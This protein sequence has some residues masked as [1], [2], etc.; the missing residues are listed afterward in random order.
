MGLTDRLRHLRM[1]ARRAWRAWRGSPVRLRRFD[2]LGEDEQLEFKRQ[3]RQTVE[4]MD[5]D[6]RQALID[7][8]Q[9]D[10]A[11][12]LEALDESFRGSN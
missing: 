11:E 7:R 4:D 2:V 12:E 9:E 3:L 6:V 10:N 1:R 8:L 5:E